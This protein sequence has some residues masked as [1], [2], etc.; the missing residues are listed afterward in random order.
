MGQFMEHTLYVDIRYIVCQQNNFITE[1]FMSVFAFQIFW[2]DKTTL[3]KTS[4][5]ST[6]T[7]KWIKDID[8]LV[9][10]GAIKL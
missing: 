8:I 4:N 5:E 6:R 1:N 3:H 2:L 9:R 7:H 10:Q